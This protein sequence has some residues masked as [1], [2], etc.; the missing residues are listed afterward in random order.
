MYAPSCFG[1]NSKH[2]VHDSSIYMHIK[3]L[4][5]H[6]DFG[7][8]CNSSNCSTEQEEDMDTS[9]N[10]KKSQYDSELLEE[11]NSSSKAAQKESVSFRDNE[12]EEEDDGDRLERDHKTLNRTKTES[13]DKDII[14]KH[15][16]GI[17]MLKRNHK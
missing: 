4:Q 8:E 7:T 5:T 15:L 12:S 17:T 2:M 13:I 1:F 3:K 10:V 9:N 11:S 16:K 14:K 6:T